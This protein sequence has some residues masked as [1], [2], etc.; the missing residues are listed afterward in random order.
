MDLLL[1]YY[2]KDL[3]YIQDFL[4][5]KAATL[6]SLCDEKTLKL[7]VLISMTIFTKEF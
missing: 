2:I 7:R 3:N 6:I 5:L 4:K 1:K